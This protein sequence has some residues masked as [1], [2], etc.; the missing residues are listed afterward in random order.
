MQPQKKSLALPISVGIVLPIV[1]LVF[2]GLSALLKNFILGDIG[3]SPTAD[4]TSSGLSG[5]IGIFVVIGVV[6]LV[7]GIIWT[8]TAKQKISK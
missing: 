6:W 1:F 8:V 3:S 2:T 5:T 7:A 4:G